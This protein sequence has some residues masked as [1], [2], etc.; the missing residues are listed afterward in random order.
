M[1]ANSVNLGYV[2]PQLSP[3]RVTKRSNF[4][5]GVVSKNGDTMLKMRKGTIW[6]IVDA[7]TAIPWRMKNER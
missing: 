4:L 5:R 6:K 2:S 1:T 3:V 7:V